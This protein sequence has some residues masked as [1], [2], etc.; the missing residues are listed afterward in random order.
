MA[1]APL[2][3]KDLDTIKA[4]LRLSKLAEER[5]GHALLEEALRSVRIGFIRELTKSR[6]DDIADTALV[7]TPS[8]D[9]EVM[10]V[11]AAVTE[12]LWVRY[13]LMA[14]M[15]SAFLDAGA[16]DTVQIWNDEGAF[17]SG[18][19]QGFQ[20]RRSALWGEITSNLDLLKSQNVGAE[21]SVKSFVLE[22]ESTKTSRPG[23]S[24]GIV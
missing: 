15:P 13:Q 19:A 4:K 10:R 14:T 24:A 9:D 6:V 3:E 18:S 5:D 20:E 22:P 8:T 7:D 21:A 17:R 11:A 1:V 16:Q 2:F 23:E 12:V